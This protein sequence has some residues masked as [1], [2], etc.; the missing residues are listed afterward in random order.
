MAERDGSICPTWEASWAH[1]K[2]AKL[3]AEIARKCP[4]FDSAVPILQQLWVK[5]EQSARLS[6][7]KPEPLS[8]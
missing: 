6:L 1:L 5:S 4:D 8:C 7:A 3:S 2:E